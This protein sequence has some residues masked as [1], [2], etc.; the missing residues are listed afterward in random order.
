MS[1]HES[2]L[3]KPRPGYGSL[4]RTDSPSSSFKDVKGKGRM[5]EDDLEGMKASLVHR[6]KAI[7]TGA[8]LLQSFPALLLIVPVDNAEL[9]RACQRILNNRFGEPKPLEMGDSNDALEEKTALVL[10]ALL[11]LVRDIYETPIQSKRSADVVRYLRRKKDEEEFVGKLL[12]CTKDVLDLACDQEEGEEELGLLMNPSVLDNLIL[13]SSSR[14]IHPSLVPL[15]SHPLLLTLSHIRWSPSTLSSPR[16]L[17]RLSLLWNLLFLLL[18]LY[19][20]MFS[21]YKHQHH[22]NP[23]VWYYE[24]EEEGHRHAETAGRAIIWWAV[25]VPSVLG[26]TISVLKVLYRGPLS[27]PHIRPLPPGSLPPLL[28]HSMLFLSLILRLTFPL[29]LSSFL[30]YISYVLLC[31]S[32]PLLFSSAFLLPSSLPSL[33]PAILPSDGGGLKSFFTLSALSAHF[34][35]FRHSLLFLCVFGLALVWS[36][37]GEIDVY[38]PDV[39]WD[40]F[41][42]SSSTSPSFAP[43]RGEGPHRGPKGSGAFGRIAP[44]EARTSIALGL[45]VALLMSWVGGTEEM[46]IK[47]LKEGWRLDVWATAEWYRLLRAFGPREGE[48]VIIMPPFNW[49]DVAFVILPSAF[50]KEDRRKAWKKRARSMI[51]ERFMRPQ[52]WVMF[53][54]RKVLERMRGGRR[55]E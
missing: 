19:L 3:Q 16:H 29:H 43:G 23:F 55:T 32:L 22:P 54:W 53:G 46:R 10:A 48:E 20:A 15:L 8:K 51:M 14:L 26:Y 45:L 47:E 4:L 42:I 25:W 21:E 36:L 44:M 35:G 39:S 50:M 9:S 34:R 37:N 28:G 33:N 7:P 13:L 41:N 49:V 12:E 5:L 17:H 52:L 40:D 6:L 18:T 27:Y 31:Y 2:L 30:A 1:D 38:D 11:S 24:E